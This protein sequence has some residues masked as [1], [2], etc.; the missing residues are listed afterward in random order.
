M[1]RARFPLVNP[2]FLCAVLKVF[3]SSFFFFLLFRTVFEQ[4]E[5]TA[6]AGGRVAIASVRAARGE[7]GGRRA[8]PS[9]A[10]ASDRGRAP[11][12]RHVSATHLFNQILKV[13]SR[14]ISPS[15][16]R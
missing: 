15:T 12:T 5:S 14:R 16:S 3:P 9:E 13:N 2:R 11:A 8:E 7:R 10:Q 4:A 6:E 1:A